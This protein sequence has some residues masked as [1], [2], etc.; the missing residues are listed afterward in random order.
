MRTSTRNPRAGG[1]PASKQ[2]PTGRQPGERGSASALLRRFVRQDRNDAWAV[3][4]LPRIA[5]GF[6]AAYTLFALA[7]SSGSS[8]VAVCGLLT[9]GLVVRLLRRRRQLLLGLTSTLLTAGLTSYFATAGEAARWGTSP[10]VSGEAVFGYW[11]LAGMAL[12]G[13]WI[14][15]NHPGG[16]G[17]TVVGADLIIAIASGVGMV[18]PE[19]GVPLGFVGVSAFLTLRGGS[20]AA[21][22]S[23]IRKAS[24]RWFG[25]KSPTGRDS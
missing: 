25:L 18:W 5:F 15:K 2:S 23:R 7:S 4:L 12:L 1:K 21:V 20:A 16:R 6:A 24:G 22:R 8:F 9:L 3:R 11:A 14:P 13:A 17:V 19:A 10:V